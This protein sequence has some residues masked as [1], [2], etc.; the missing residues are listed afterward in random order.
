MIGQTINRKK[1]QTI[2]M[3]C[4]I[5]QSSFPW[6][7]ENIILHLP[8]DE[9]KTLD[10]DIFRY[11]EFNCRHFFPMTWLFSC[12]SIEEFHRNNKNKIA[13]HIFL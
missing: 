9:K 12:L 7:F 2:M 5:T 11:I 4:L 1:Q 6:K 10:F 3:K 8:D 13:I